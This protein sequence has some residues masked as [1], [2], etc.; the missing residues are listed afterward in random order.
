MSIYYLIDPFTAAGDITDVITGSPSLN[1]INATGST[2]IRI[3]DGVALNDDPTNLADLLNE[4]YDGLLAFYAGF[5]DIVADACMDPLTVDLVGPPVS[6]GVLVSEGYVHHCILPSGNLRT[7]NAPLTSAP[8]AVIVVW[9]TYRLTT[10]DNATT[11]LTR[12]YV[13]DDTVL[14]TCDVDFGGASPVLNVTNGAVT[15]IPVADQFTNLILTF[16]NTDPGRV[17]LGSWAVIGTW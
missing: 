11:R 15:N 7:V 10:T 1:P 3:P 16:T 17:Y 9:E 8:T 13:E 5:T 12:E 6:T 4:K 14:V 2:V